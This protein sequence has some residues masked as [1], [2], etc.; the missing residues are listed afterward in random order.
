MEARAGL[1]APGQGKAA[2]EQAGKTAKEANANKALAGGFGGPL[3]EEGQLQVKGDLAEFGEA[4]TSATSAVESHTQ[5][6]LDATKAELEK[7]QAARQISEVESGTLLKAIAD[8][9]SGQ[10][11]G[12]NYHGRAMTAGAGSAARY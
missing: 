3:S 2:N 9:V 10:I 1:L 5:A 7:A 11:G 4:L 6:V 8:L 12:V